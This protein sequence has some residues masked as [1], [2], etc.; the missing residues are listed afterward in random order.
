MK[1]TCTIHSLDHKNSEFYGYPI[2]LDWWDYETI[3]NE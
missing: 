1:V 2:D 3:N